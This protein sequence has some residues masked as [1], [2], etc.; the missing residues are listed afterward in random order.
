MKLIRFGSPDHE[1]PGVILDDGRRI[2]ISAFGADYDEL[3]LAGV[4]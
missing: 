1:I 2:D 3:F 4:L